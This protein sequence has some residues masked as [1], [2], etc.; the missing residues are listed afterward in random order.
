VKALPDNTVRRFLLA[1]TKS[2]E[3]R[4]RQRIN[5]RAR[6]LFHITTTKT[7]VKKARTAIQDPKGQDVPAILVAALKQL[8]KA[9]QKGVIH[10]QTAARKKSRLMQAFNSKMGQSA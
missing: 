8:D 6:N 4:N 2:A 9:A 7:L 1:N 3:K 10:D 5:R